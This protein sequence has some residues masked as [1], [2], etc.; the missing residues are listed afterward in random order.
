MRKIKPFLLFLLSLL[1]LFIAAAIFLSSTY[2]KDI[3]IPNGI[4]GQHIEVV[5]I[6]LRVH[7]TGSGPDI[8]FLHGSIGNLED[9]ETVAPLLTGFRITSV[10]RFGHGYS[11]MADRKAT[12]KNNAYFIEQ[13][14]ETLDLKDVILVGHSYGGSTALQ[15]AINQTQQQTSR[16]KAMVLLAPAG[17][18]L[19]STDPLE[20]ILSLPV[21]GQ[22]LIRMVQPFLAEDMLREGLLRS[23]NPNQDKVPENFI[24]SRVSLWNNPGVLYTRTQQTS[25]VIKE[26]TE[27]SQQ[28]QSIAVPTIIML[29]EH[30]T[31]EDIREGCIK[32]ASTIP[33]AELVMLPDAGHYLQYHSPEK[34]AQQIQ[35]INQS[36]P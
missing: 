34:V 1:F 35:L 16:I 30:E 20:H 18:P 3:T 22:G 27:I 29:G 24:N 10:D 5:G 31:F 15:M 23:L 7:Q 26:L 19:A 6:K 11:A 13:L 9:F 17:Y 32:L 33:G 8:V 4:A 36:A 28:V 12:I 21:I 2:K 25:V 14:I